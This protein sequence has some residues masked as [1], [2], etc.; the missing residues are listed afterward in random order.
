VVLGTVTVVVAT[1]VALMAS[2]VMVRVVVM[3]TSSPSP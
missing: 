2:E 3:V 1:L